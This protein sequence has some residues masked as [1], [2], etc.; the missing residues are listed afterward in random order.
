M[1]MRHIENLMI[2]FPTTASSKI[3]TTRVEEW[4]RMVVTAST[5]DGLPLSHSALR[6]NSGFGA[7][8]SG[9]SVV[10][11]S[12]TPRDITDAHGVAQAQW[13]Q[14]MAEVAILGWILSGEDWSQIDSSHFALSHSCWNWKKLIDWSI[15][16]FLIHVWG[17]IIPYHCISSL[18]VPN[19]D[20]EKPYLEGLLIDIAMLKKEH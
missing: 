10:H 13:V 3:P 11:A 17:W 1:I 2:H 8:A 15:I 5:Q 20:I 18:W 14:R 6:W 16:R 9:G 12:G 7:S 4:W 19:V